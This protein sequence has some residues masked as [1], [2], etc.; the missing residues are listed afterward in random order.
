MAEPTPAVEPTPAAQPDAA[1]TPAAPAPPA[2]ATIT[3]S[4]EQFEQ[5]LGR[6]APQVPA[7]AGAESAPP[8]AQATEE[9]A[10]AAAAAP[11]ASAVQESEQDRITRLVNEGIAAARTNII[12][13][14][15]EQGSGPVR[16]GLVAPVNE[17]TA[18]AAPDGWPEGWPTENGSPKPLH[19]WS[20]NERREHAFP[21]LEQ[22]VLGARA[23]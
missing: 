18:P 8:P 10:P 23:R 12:Q 16:K 17:H 9:T 5:L 4:S 22:Y 20:E 21:A 1:A 6:F 15:V 7:M 11:A 2:A 14:M 13:E 3:L 19:K